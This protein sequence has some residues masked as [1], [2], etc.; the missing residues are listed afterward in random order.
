[1]VAYQQPGYKAKCSP[2]LVYESANV[3]CHGYLFKL[4][5][6]PSPREGVKEDSVRKKE[7]GMR[8]GE[9]WRKKC[10]L[11]EGKRKMR[12]GRGRKGEK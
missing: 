3:C 12:M 11:G 10:G 8:V 5:F 2:M 9:G 7:N 4:S 1:M 6:T